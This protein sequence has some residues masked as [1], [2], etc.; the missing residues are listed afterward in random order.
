[1]TASLHSTYHSRMQ[2]GPHSMALFQGSLWRFRN[3]PLIELLRNTFLYPCGNHVCAWRLGTAYQGL[4]LNHGAIAQT[5]ASQLTGW[6]FTQ[7]IRPRGLPDWIKV[8]GQ[9]EHLGYLC[10][11]R[12]TR[13]EYIF[14]AF[15]SLP[16]LETGGESSALPSGVIKRS[17]WKSTRNRGFSRKITELNRVV[18]SYPCLITRG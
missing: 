6:L 4:L 7:Y 11:A 3:I 13:G 8:G 1:M 14:G 5:W 9:T 10:S 17:N 16:Y 12:V 2:P 15:P 18:S